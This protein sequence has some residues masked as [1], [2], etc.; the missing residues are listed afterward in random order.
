[1]KSALLYS[2]ICIYIHTY[3][4]YQSKLSP[5]HAE[6]PIGKSSKLFGGRKLQKKSN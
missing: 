2:I 3:I 5:A 1:M 6:M 4:K